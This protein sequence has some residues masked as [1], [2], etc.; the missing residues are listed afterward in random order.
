VITSLGKLSTLEQRWLGI[1]PSRLVGR[2]VAPSVE[3]ADSVGGRVRAI[4]FVW[5]VNKCITS[6]D[7]H[8]DP[9]KGVDFMNSDQI[10]GTWKQLKGKIKQRW[11][12]LT[13][14]QLDIVSGNWDR[15]SGLIQTHYGEAKEEAERQVKEF[16]EQYETER[17]IKAGR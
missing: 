3:G 8:R 16:R 7:I 11:G 17:D 1:G 14:D 2:G 12:Q 13:D 15:L 5:Q 10:E 9:L 4:S 6:V